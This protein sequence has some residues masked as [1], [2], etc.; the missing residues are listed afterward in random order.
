MKKMFICA[1]VLQFSLLSQAQETTFKPFKFDIALGYAIPGG[2]GTKGGVIFA[3]EPKY[4]LNDA[5]TL[6]LRWEGAAMVRATVDETGE[7]VKGDAK[8]SASYLLTGDYYFNTNRFRPFAGIG[9]GLYRNAAVRIESE[10]IETDMKTSSK[11]G[12]APRVGFEFGHFRTAIEYNVAGKVGNYN[13]NYLG[14]KM[15]FFIGGGRLN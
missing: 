14:I 4:A 7:D 11:F 5:I 2:S 6:G 15:G 1:L 9:A 13:N 12:F 10:D 8:A 3:F